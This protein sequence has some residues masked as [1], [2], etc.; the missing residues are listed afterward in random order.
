MSNL[1][2]NVWLFVQLFSYFMDKYTIKNEKVYKT[3]TNKISNMNINSIETD[4]YFT[5]VDRCKIKE[6]FGIPSCNLKEVSLAHA[7][8]KSGNKTQPHKHDFIEIYI[9]T[10]GNAVMYI[11][12]EKKDIK[13]GQSVLIEKQKE[14]SIENTGTEDLCFYCVCTPAFTVDKTKMK[15]GEAKE[16][17]ERDFN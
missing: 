10:K 13:E 6:L 1:Y 5:A 12:N 7:I 15:D 16:S 17:I 8:L 9:I 2:I 4:D 14:H 11:E 3:S